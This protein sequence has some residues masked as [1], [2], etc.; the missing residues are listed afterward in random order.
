M[1]TYTVSEVRD[2][3]TPYDL[4][5]DE[6][7]DYRK[8]V[9]RAFRDIRRREGDATFQRERPEAYRRGYG[10]ARALVLAGKV[11]GLEPDI[12]PAHCIDPR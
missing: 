2:W 8:G 5:P 3:C 1:T 11:E 7:K 6:R 12:V 9:K 10:S 4:D